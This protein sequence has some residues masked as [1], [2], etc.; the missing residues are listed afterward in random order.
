MKIGW[1]M[2]LFCVAF[3]LRAEIQLPDIISDHM[4]LQADRPVAIWG[5]AN[6]KDT[7]TVEFSGQKKETVA[8]DAGDWKVLLDPMSSDSKPQKIKVFSSA[9]QVPKI[10]NVVLV[11]DVWLASGQSNMSWPVLRCLN[12]KEEIA[13]ANHPQMRIFLAER[14][15][16]EKAPRY[17][18]GRWIVCWPGTVGQVS[19]V[20]FYFARELLNKTA[21]PQAILNVNWGG[22]PI[23]PWCS[24]KLLKSDTLF[25]TSLEREWKHPHWVP[26]SCR[27]SMLAP[28]FAYSLR[29][30]LWYQGEGNSGRSEQYRSLFPAMIREWR[31]EFGE[32]LPFY[33]VQL[34][35]QGDAPVLFQEKSGWSALREAQMLA[36][37][38]PKT[39]MVVTHDL[40][41]PGNVHYPDKKTVGER[42]SRIA[43]EDLYGLDKNARSPLFEKVEFKNGRALVS[44]HGAELGLQHEGEIKGF[45]V[46]GSNGEFYPATARVV[47]G[48]QVEA[49]S[50]QVLEPKTIRYAWSAYPVANLTDMMGQPVSGFRSDGPASQ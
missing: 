46:A 28:L 15:I 45:V 20:G 18:K 1:I 6:P 2:L 7:I 33:F 48:S 47:N 32:E 49:W 41:I 29:G 35:T 38:E 9:E 8:S 44:F 31:A 13:Q 34:A 22:T 30:I 16:H 23:E 50:E 17:T 14:V 36:L 12:G 19:G 43:L 11:G 24:Q 21:R 42:L 4:M 26:T 3:S 10:I 5:W 25:A 40:G 37:A 39:G 27:R